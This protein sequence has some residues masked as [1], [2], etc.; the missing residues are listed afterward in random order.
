MQ[1]KV[2]S[3]VPKK[4]SEKNFSMIAVFPTPLSPKKRSLIRIYPSD[5]VALLWFFPIYVCC[6]EKC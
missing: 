1:P 3:Y 4:V 6:A 5:V 2:G